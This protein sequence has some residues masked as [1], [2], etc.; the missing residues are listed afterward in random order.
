MNKRDRDSVTYDLVRGQGN[1]VVYR[2]TTSQ[3]VEARAAQHRAEGKKFDRIV[4][5]SR[6]MTEDGA[7]RKEAEN[8]ARYRSGHGGRNPLY[9]ETDDG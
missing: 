5:T 4:Q 3:D 7:R 2:G 6:R 8:L 1:R 9:N